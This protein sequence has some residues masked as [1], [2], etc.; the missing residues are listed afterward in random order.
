[1]SDRISS[2]RSGS[3]C[4]GV[5]LSGG[6]GQGSVSMRLLQSPVA[7]ALLF[8]QGRAVQGGLSYSN[9]NVERQSSS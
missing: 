5:M 1:V 8:L 3:G 4:C 9:Q 2:Q 6:V 7:I